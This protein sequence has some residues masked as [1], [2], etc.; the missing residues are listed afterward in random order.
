MVVEATGTKQASLPPLQAL[1]FAGGFGFDLRV[2]IAHF[3]D[4]S[5]GLTGVG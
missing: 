2:V 4:A 5:A 1:G 3:A